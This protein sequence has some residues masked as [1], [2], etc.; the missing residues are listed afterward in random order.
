MRHCEHCRVDIKGDWDS[1]PLCQRSLDTEAEVTVPNP[2]PD[3]PLR[4]NKQYVMSL[5]TWLSLI[6]IVAYFV[7]DM[8]LRDKL[9]GLRLLLFGVMSMW[10]VVL[11]LIRKRRNIAKGIVYLIVSIS[12]LCVYWDYAT[13]W[14]GW[15]TTYVVPIVCS[16][17]LVALFIAVRVVRLSVGDYV[18]YLLAAALIGLFPALFLL[19]DWVTQPLP[20]WI[21][22]GMSAAMLSLILIFQGGDIWVE[23]QKR[24]NI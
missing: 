21:S 18:L 2:Y 3:I 10:L 4:F 8:L 12:L 9:E 15:S 16:F 11:I 13:G 14:E 7:V 24:M 1:C 5:L 23:W 22:V 6:L 17:A 19:L 20:S